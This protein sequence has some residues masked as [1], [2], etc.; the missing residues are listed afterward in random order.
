MTIIQTVAQQILGLPK[1]GSLP[2]RLSMLVTNNKKKK[3]PKSAS[4]LYRPS[5]R[6]VSAKLVPT[7]LWVDGATWSA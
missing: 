3:L 7:L 4:E 5:D 6:R 1:V 2:R